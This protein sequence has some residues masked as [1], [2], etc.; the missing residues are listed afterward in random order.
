MTKTK[1]KFVTPSL[2]LKLKSRNYV[3]SI[4][5]SKIRTR[6]INPNFHDFSK[7]YN[8]VVCTKVLKES[9]IVRKSLTVVGN[10]IAGKAIGNTI[11]PFISVHEIRD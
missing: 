2:N 9:K 8:C 5:V 11:I 7:N 3:P 6:I 10:I 1:E 4:L